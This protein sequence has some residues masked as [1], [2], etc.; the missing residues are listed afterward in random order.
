MS[1]VFLVRSLLLVRC[2]AHQMGPLFIHELV[3][4]SGNWRTNS[5][6]LVVCLGLFYGLCAE[7]EDPEH[8]LCGQ[9]VKGDIRRHSGLIGDIGC[10]QIAAK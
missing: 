4:T 8:L 5:F 7:P 6:P 1:T 2:T 9:R 10:G 3:T